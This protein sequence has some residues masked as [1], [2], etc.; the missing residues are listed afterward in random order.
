MADTRG[1]VEQLSD[2]ARH[3]SVARYRQQRDMVRHQTAMEEAA[4]EDME[5][6]QAGT[7]L[8]LCLALMD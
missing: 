7:P 8:A 3:E 1:E 6:A 2:E 4:K 5:L